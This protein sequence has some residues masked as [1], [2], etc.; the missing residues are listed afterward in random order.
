MPKLAPLIEAIVVVGVLV[1]LFLG[2]RRVRPVGAYALQY[3][4]YGSVSEVTQYFKPYI[5]PGDS[6][7]ISS[8][9]PGD[10]VGIRRRVQTL[11]AEFPGYPIYFRTSGWDR[12]R[13]FINTMPLDL[14]EAFPAILHTYEPGNEALYGPYPPQGP[15]DFQWVFDQYRQVTTLAHQRGIDLWAVPSGRYVPERDLANYNWDYGVLGTVVD[16]VIVQTQGSCKAGK[17]PATVRSMNQQFANAGVTTPWMPM[18][19][20]GLIGEVANSVPAVESWACVLEAERQ[21]LRQHA[22]QWWDMQQ[23]LHFLDLREAAFR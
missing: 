22:H 5:R 3:H 4:I 19:A 18:T 17:M 10:W 16:R 15:H 11:N 12:V 6:F 20:V 14:I 21:G 23:A 8:I 1:G 13:D 7:V 2:L 9:I